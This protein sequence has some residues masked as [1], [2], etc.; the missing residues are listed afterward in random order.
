[1]LCRL[2]AVAQFLVGPVDMVLGQM[3]ANFEIGVPGRGNPN[4]ID[5]SAI[6]DLP[7]RR[8]DEAKLVYA[9]KARQRRNQPDIWTFR[10]L[11]RTN[12]PIMSRMN[13]ADLEPRTLPGQPAWPECRQSALV[14]DFRQRIGLVHELRELRRSEELPDRRRNRLRV[15][16]VARHRSLHLL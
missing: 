3:I 5:D 6:L 15:N 14:S 13:V 9:R 16:Q 4:M 10:R 11:D 7:V 8:F 2:L 12:A 1:V